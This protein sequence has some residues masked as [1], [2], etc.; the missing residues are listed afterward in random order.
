M[1]VTV[2]LT[3]SQQAREADTKPRLSIKHYICSCNVSFLVCKRQHKQYFIWPWLQLK[4][5]KV[6]IDLKFKTIL[7]QLK[8][9]QFASNSHHKNM[10]SVKI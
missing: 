10:F 6:I 8:C 4:V 1:R 7:S 9:K 5:P 2:I 3:S